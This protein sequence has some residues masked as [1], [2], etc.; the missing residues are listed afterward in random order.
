METNGRFRCCR[1]G[2]VGRRMAP[3]SQRFLPNKS[4]LQGLDFPVATPTPRTYK[5]RRRRTEELLA[6]TRAT[7]NRS[8]LCRSVVRITAQIQFTGRP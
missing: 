6:A 4:D 3:I 2:L 1:L 7:C 5:R 8:R